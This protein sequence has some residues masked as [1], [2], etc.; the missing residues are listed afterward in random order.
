M[1]TSRNNNVVITSKRRRF[2]LWRYRVACTLGKPVSRTFKYAFVQPLMIAN[3]HDE[4]GL[5]ASNDI[6]LLTDWPQ[7][8]IYNAEQLCTIWV[9]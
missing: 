5:Q 8:G 9:D 6:F 2:A 4:V 1:D 3:I 7:R